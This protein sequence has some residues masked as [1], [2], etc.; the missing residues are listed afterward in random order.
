MVFGTKSEHLI[1]TQLRILY[2][3]IKCHRHVDQLELWKP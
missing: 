1:F 2:T 3:F